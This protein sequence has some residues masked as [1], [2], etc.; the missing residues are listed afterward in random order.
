M[1]L[2]PVSR[3]LACLAGVVLPAIVF[4]QNGTALVR[5][6]PA[7]N[8]TV[9]GSVRLLTPES[10]TLNGGATVT[11]DLLV[12][13]TPTVRLNGK[14]DYAGTLDGAGAAAPSNHQ[15]TLNGGAALRHVVR[16]TDAVPLAAIA[17]PPAPTGT[18]SVT[19]NNAGQTAGDFATLRNLTLNGNVGAVAVPPGSYG[20]FT[21]NSGGFTLGVPGAASPAHYAFQSLTLNGSATLAVVGPVV[22][23]LAGGF[24]ANGG[25]LGTAARPD[26]LAARFAAGG[27]TL[28]G[29]VSVYGYIEAPAGTVTLNGNARLVGGVAADRLT[30][31]G[32]AL[33]RLVAPPVANVPPTVVMT[34]P[35]AG[36]EFTAPAA[37]LLRASAGD[38]DGTVSRVDFFRDGTRLGEDTAAPYEWPVA[39]LA[40]GEYAFS[41]RATDNGGA[42]ADSAPVTVIVRAANRPPTV[43]LV[44]PADGAVFPA[45]SAILL[46]ATAADADQAIAR[47][48][49]FSGAAKLGEKTAPPYDWPLSAVA[50]GSYTFRVRAT[51]TLGAATDSAPVTVRVNAPPVVALTAPAS[52]ASLLAPA[53]FTL[54]ATATDADGTVARVEFYRDAT[55]LGE[56]AAVPYTWPVAGL[57]AGT[58]AFSAR[59]FDNDGALGASNAAVVTVLA[60]NASP[61]VALTSPVPG[62]LFNSPAMI[63]LEAAVND[64]DGMVVRVEFFAD[65]A[66]IGE[67]GAAPF[68]FVWTDVAPGAYVFT[69]VAYDQ[70]GASATSTPVDIGVGD[71]S[72]KLFE[73]GF[74]VTDG[75]RTGPLAGQGEWTV[76]GG[77][78]ITETEVQSGQQALRL[79]PATLPSRL[80]R[81]FE[82]DVPQDIVFLDLLVRPIAAD[83]ADR[84]L[85]FDAGGARVALVKHGDEGEFRV[86]HGDGF[87]SGAWQR[88]LVENT[89]YLSD[90]GVTAWWPRVTMRIDYVR[91][92]WDLIVDGR[93]IA[94]DVGL[95]D[96]SVTGFGRFVVFGHAT[97]AV[98][99][100][101]LSLGFGN[102]VYSDA[103]RDGMDDGWEAGYGLNIA[104]ND[105]D[106]DFD[107]D[108][109]TNL[110]EFIFDTL[111]DDS[112]SDNDGLTDGFETQHGFDP[113]NYEYPFDADEDGKNQFEE[114]VA[115]TD[116]ADFFNGAT[117]QITVLSGEGSPTGEFVVKIHRPDGTPYA[118]AP[119]TFEVD[120]VAAA[121]A[122]NPDST[123]TGRQLGL[124]SDAAGIVRIFL[125]PP[126]VSPA[127]GEEVVP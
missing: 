97:H 93:M 40:A 31:N 54:A 28:N 100:D 74:E 20:A 7:L 73:T 4:A 53:D 116:P 46:T 96:A 38:T 118:N 34:E 64:T 15:V 81:S 50:A 91:K 110:R 106:L 39:A 79:L 68:G 72:V 25:P 82:S 55:K 123:V 67:D 11:G 29:N 27:L 9:E 37:F 48:E 113:W 13:G 103:D 109:L 47:V 6:A 126:P 107:N 1:K 12:P 23:T 101:A 42:T 71:F 111:A 70:Q 21:A 18:R 114:A 83:D 58:Y 33:L 60:P 95:T 66:K 59:A 122:T 127:A 24:A 5:R 41:A 117:P 119:V 57:A 3:L 92:T 80:E 112:D 10:V 32:G 105:R 85:I 45:G 35:V 62:T 77:A 63:T 88:P 43:S 108:T 78:E 90:S 19:V 115:G 17:A 99:L 102:P 94:A 120:A 44:A 76:A 87:G 98:G 30:V 104:A 84:G 16:R 125:R 121:L 36:T 75:Y 61:T 86:F 22:V 69:A 49:F 2:L 14:P 52:G 26:W 56:T 65:G 51:D 8:G 124:R 89:V